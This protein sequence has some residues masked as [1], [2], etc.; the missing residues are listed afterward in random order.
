MKEKILKIYMN[1]FM[2]IVYF[3]SLFGLKDLLE[4]IGI[5][6]N[7]K[8]YPI[9]SYIFLIIYS[10]SFICLIFYSDKYLIE[11]NKKNIDK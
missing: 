2:V 11:K 9:S 6:K 8:L 4:K 1:I 3:T 10:C 5:F 7:T